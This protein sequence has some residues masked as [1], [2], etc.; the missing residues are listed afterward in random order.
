MRIIV[1]AGPATRMRHQGLDTVEVRTLLRFAAEQVGSSGLT[2][3][4]V[5][6]RY[7]RLAVGPLRWRHASFAEGHSGLRYSLYRCDCIGVWFRKR[8]IRQKSGAS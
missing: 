4:L 5:R 2:V 3:G 8:L 6:P 7:P 1:P